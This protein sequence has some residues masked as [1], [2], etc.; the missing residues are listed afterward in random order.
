M[1]RAAWTDQRLDDLAQR[2]DTGFERVDRD[3]RDLR[4]E[5]GSMRVEMGNMRVEMGQ[6][7]DALQA[8][9]MRF[10]GATIVCLLGAIVAVSLGGS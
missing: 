10:G 5:L 7:F 3:I 6:R 2:M 8:T 4:T 9:M 1:E